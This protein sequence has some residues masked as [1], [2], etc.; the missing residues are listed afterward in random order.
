MISIYKRTTLW[1]G[2]VCLV[3]MSFHKH[4]GWSCDWQWLRDVKLWKLRWDCLLIEF[5]WF[6][7]Y[8]WKFWDIRERIFD[9][10]MRQA[11][12]KA[13]VSFFMINSTYMYVDLC[14][15][16]RS[17]VRSMSQQGNCCWRLCTLNIVA[18]R[19]QYGYV[20]SFREVFCQ[21]RFLPEYVRLIWGGQ[22]EVILFCI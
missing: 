17:S 4:C 11:D 16:I 15:I 10:V 22:N 3:F 13:V 20:S 8:E 7:L 18:N 6:Q 9:L 12:Q 19:S 1:C 14:N 5:L 21:Q 2:V